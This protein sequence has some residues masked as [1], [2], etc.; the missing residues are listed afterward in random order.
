MEV[1]PPE[2]IEDIMLDPSKY[3]LPTF[4]QFAK[5][6]DAYRMGEGFFMATLD[7]GSKVMINTRHDKYVVGGYDCGRGSHGLTQ[8]QYVASNFGHSLHKLKY[9]CQ[10]R[11]DTSCKYYIEHTFEV[12]NVPASP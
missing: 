9:S 12:P 3:G 1:K 7:N 6:P 4:A 5:N 8:A 10:V 2:T 11:E